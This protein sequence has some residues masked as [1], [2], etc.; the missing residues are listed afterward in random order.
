MRRAAGQPLWSVVIYPLWNGVIYAIVSSPRWSN[1]IGE[2]LSIRLGL[3]AM[4]VGALATA[5]FTAISP[6]SVRQVNPVRQAG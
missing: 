6:A 4:A 5:I 1:R 3:V 2:E